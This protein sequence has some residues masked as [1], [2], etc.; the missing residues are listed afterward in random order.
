MI[1]LL[2]SGVEWS[3]AEYDKA[4]GGCPD[5]LLNFSC[6]AKTKSESKYTK[7][8]FKQSHVK[9]HVKTLT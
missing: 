9:T 8:Y 6:K 2:Y 3:P 4:I 7:A 1:N 5:F